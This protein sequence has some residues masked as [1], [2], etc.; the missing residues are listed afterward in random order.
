MLA[1][2]RFATAGRKAVPQAAHRSAAPLPT[3]GGVGKKSSGMWAA[4]AD[5]DSEESDTGSLGAARGPELSRRAGQ[6]GRSVS[7]AKVV[8]TPVFVVPAP[9]PAVLVVKKVEAAGPTDIAAAWREMMESDPFFL[10]MER[11][12]MWGDLLY[13]RPAAVVVSLSAAAEEEADP[14]AA[15]YSHPHV[16]LRA[17]EGDLWA[18]PFTGDLEE[19]WPDTYDTREMSDSD[20]HAMMT[21]IYSK[22]WHVEAYDR[23]GVHAYPDNASALRWNPATME[24]EEPNRVRWADEEAARAPAPHAHAGCGHRA[25]AKKERGPV[26]IPRFCRGGAAC[27]DAGGSCRYVHGDT[28]PRV[29]E[30]C[31]FGAGCGASDPT[32]VKRSQ[33]LRMHPGEE[34]SPELV[35]RR[36]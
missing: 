8:S 32:G 17:T 3:A 28:I 19:Y 29:N 23:A 7:P 2:R 35:I 24:A 4:L 11:G 20:Y 10:A 31:A 25:P 33:C 26:T 14:L 1:S 18:Q 6:A 21:W 12:E 22:G 36:L 34:W 5:S 27:P 9:A 13:E 16:P 30:P 15:I